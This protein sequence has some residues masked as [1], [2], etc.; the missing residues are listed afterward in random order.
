MDARALA[1]DGQEQV[2]IAWL[3][4]GVSRESRGGDR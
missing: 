2:A 4:T 1:A 3:P